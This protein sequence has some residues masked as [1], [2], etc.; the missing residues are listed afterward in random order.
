MSVKK[1][2]Y[3]LP[4]LKVFVH[5]D[6]SSIWQLSL[7]SHSFRKGEFPTFLSLLAAARPSFPVITNKPSTSNHQAILSKLETLGFK[8]VKDSYLTEAP[9][10]WNPESLRRGLQMPGATEM[11]KICDLNG[12]FELSLAEFCT[13]AKGDPTLY[14][15]FKHGFLYLD[16]NKDTRIVLSEL[17][18]AYQ[19]TEF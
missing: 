6:G 3:D 17:Y 2:I 8:H 4:P 16:K 1:K 19:S 5:N 10:V 11:F 9:I 12:D 14:E 15:R 7:G 13:P 18:Q